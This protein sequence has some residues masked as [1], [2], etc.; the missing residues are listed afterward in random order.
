MNRPRT[1]EVAATLVPNWT[2]PPTNLRL[3]PTDLHLWL[4]DTTQTAQPPDPTPL[5]A[6]EQA[7]AARVSR[8]SA[9]RRFI[10]TRAWQRQIL[11]AYLQLDPASVPLAR[12]PKGKPFIDLPD[13]DLRFNLS[14]SGDLALLAAMRGRDIGVDLE[15]QDERRDLQRIAARMFPADWAADLA[16]SP[17][18]RRTG[19]FHAYWTRLEAGVKAHGGGL[20][21]STDG[22]GGNEFRHFTPQ[23]GYLGCV[24][25]RGRCPPPG[26]WRFFRFDADADSL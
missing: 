25:V 18:A 17:P 24:A 13:T 8:D 7:R 12:G 11:G 10:R 3:A 23:A 14:H 21:A 9:R 20:F 15:R 19:L 1:D 5:S 6:D 16:A 22:T 26:R 2:T 4:L